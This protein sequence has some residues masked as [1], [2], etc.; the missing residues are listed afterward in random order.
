MRVGMGCVRFQVGWYRYS[1]FGPVAV[2]DSGLYHVLC[3]ET[4]LTADNS[5]NG[6][7]GTR[8]ELSVGSAVTG[9]SVGQFFLR[10]GGGK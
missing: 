10:D 1:I 9:S 8:L 7:C 5:R 2:G 6:G 3:D 4:C